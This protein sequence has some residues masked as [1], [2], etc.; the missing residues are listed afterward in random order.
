MHV[1][2]IP[3][4]QVPSK[5]RRQVHAI[6]FELPANRKLGSQNADTW[7]FVE[8]PSK[9]QEIPNRTEPNAQQDQGNHL[10]FE[11]ME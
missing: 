2:P 8:S 6:V 7:E 3:K 5:S 11:P 1:I 10:Q 9:A 4:H